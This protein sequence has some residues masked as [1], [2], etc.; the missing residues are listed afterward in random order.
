MKEIFNEFYFFY[1]Y[2]MDAILIIKLRDLNSK[3]NENNLK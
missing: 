1:Y 2:G 3:H